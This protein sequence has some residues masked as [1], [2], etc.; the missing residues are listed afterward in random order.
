MRG[1]M[2]DRATSYTY[3][4]VEQRRALGGSVLDYS[5]DDLG[6]TMFSAPHSTDPKSG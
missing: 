3:Y 1:Q 6:E 2:A 4:T 5:F